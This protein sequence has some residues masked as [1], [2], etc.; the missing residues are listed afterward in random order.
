[1]RIIL[2]III[3]LA[4]YL[5]GIFQTYQKQFYEH[6]KFFLKNKSYLQQFNVVEREMIWKQQKA[7]TD[8]AN[9][10]RAKYK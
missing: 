3:F 4:G 9:K 5:I 2:A 6:D 1:M 8:F 10:Q 7:L